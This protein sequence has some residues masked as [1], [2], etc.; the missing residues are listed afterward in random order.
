MEDM[1]IYSDKFDT[2]V[3][4]EV[5]APFTGVY[6]HGT[7]STVLTYDIVHYSLLSNITFK[8]GIYNVIVRHTD[9]NGN[10]IDYACKL[11]YWQGKGNIEH[12]GLICFYSDV[13]SRENALLKFNQKAYCL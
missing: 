10:M 6:A 5:L 12:R 7:L 2:N 11:Y 1:F 3:Q 13:E 4:N 9:E 8:T